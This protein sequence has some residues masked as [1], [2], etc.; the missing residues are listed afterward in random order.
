LGIMMILVS[1]SLVIVATLVGAKFRLV[2]GG[3]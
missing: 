2:E 3:G 1:T